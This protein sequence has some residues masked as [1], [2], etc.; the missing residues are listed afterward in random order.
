MLWSH[1]YDGRFYLVL[2]AGLAGLLILAF[3]LAQAPGARSAVLFVLRAL[4]LGLLVLILL[5]PVR[6]NQAEYRGPEPPAFF[7][8][9]ESRSMGLEA[10]KTRARAADDLIATALARIPQQDRPPILRFGFGRELAAI[11][12]SRQGLLPQFD[13]TRLN[14]ALEELPSRFGDSAPFAVFLFSDGR[15]SE[16]ESLEPTTLAYHRMGIPV[17][18]IPVGDE[19]VSGDVAVQDID[20]PRNAQPGTRVPVRVTVR[21]HGY[22][23]QRAELQ[24]RSNMR[25]RGEPLATLPITLSGGEQAHELVIETDQA[26]GPLTV[27]VSPL[28]HEAIATNNAVPFQIMPRDPKIRVLYMEGTPEGEWAFVR[29]ALHE[30]PNIECTPLTVDNQM[31]AQQRLYRVSDPSRGFPTSRQELFSYDVV[32]CSDIARSAF[33]PQQLDWTVELVGERGGGFAMVGGYTSFGA[34]GW[35]QTSWDG[36][37]PIDMSGH[38]LGRSEYFNGPVRVVIPPRAAEHP[39]WRIV[40]DPRKNLDVLARIPEFNGTNLTDRLKP[41]ATALGLSDQPLPGSNIVTVFSAQAFGKGRSFAMAT[42]TTVGWGQQFERV[43]GEGDNRYFRKFWRNVVRWLSENSDA[44][45]RQ[46]RVETDKVIYRPGQEIQVTARA[47]DNE[48]NQTDNLRVAASLHNASQGMATGSEPTLVNLTPQLDDHSYRGKLTAP[49]ATTN[50]ENPGSTIH[51]LALNVHSLDGDR[52]VART[53]L[54]LQV[55]DDPAE[56]RD[57]RPDPAKLHTIA[58]DTSARVLRNPADL[59]AAI[60]AHPKASVRKVV[61]RWPV[62]DSL[63]LW[64]LLIGVLSAEWIVR[65]LKGLA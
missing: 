4:A 1:P 20:A 12:K 5:N 16:P 11:P 49:P 35:D 44:A 26:K 53:S 46:L 8:F 2:A 17:H 9:D 63:A 15:A 28:P 25:D 58:R 55:I 6:V 37:I 61:T 29:D 30:D 60:A 24:I 54:E 57:P 50:F 43:W 64:T 10:P 56:F 41:A 27:E 32:I 23:G 51:R 7:L 18:V 21:S 22:A 38:G 19:A 48:Q 13:E 42:D 47:Y 45:H 65:R 59:A 34:G 3:R 39:I 40:D 31:G 14:R 33:T 52:E 62:W 36:L